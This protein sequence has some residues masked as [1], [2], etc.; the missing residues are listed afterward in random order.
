MMYFFDTNICI[1]LLKGVFPEL[2]KRV[3]AT[4]PSKIKIPAMVAAELIYGAQKS[5]KAAETMEKVSDF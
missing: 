1:Y 3:L 5:K 4:Q 2:Q